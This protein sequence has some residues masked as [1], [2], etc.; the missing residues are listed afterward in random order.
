M[1]RRVHTLVQTIKLGIEL[2]R[3]TL[4]HHELKLLRSLATTAKT[5]FMRLLEDHDIT[6]DCGKCTL[7]LKVNKEDQIQLMTLIQFIMHGLAPVEAQSRTVE[8][9]VKKFYEINESALE[10]RVE[11]YL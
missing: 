2:A 5:A 6:R 11:A 9:A 3:T 10:E 4:R 1:S 7:D 8:E